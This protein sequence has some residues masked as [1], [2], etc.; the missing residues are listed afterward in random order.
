MDRMGNDVKYWK[1]N[2]SAAFPTRVESKR[3]V[4][5]THGK[6][7]KRLLTATETTRDIPEDAKVNLATLVEDGIV[8]DAWNIPCDVVTVNTRVMLK[9][10]VGGDSLQV[11]VVYPE[12]EDIAKGRVSVLT[13]LG[14]SILGRRVG[15]EIYY[16]AKTGEKRITILA[17]LYQPEAM[18]RKA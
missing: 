16:V 15:E 5:K 2:L 8:M 14:S 13:P 12:K 3:I 1:H 9:D 11:T 6:R 4:S 7:L 18:G 10:E 17:I